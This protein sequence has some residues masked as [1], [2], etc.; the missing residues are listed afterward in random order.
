MTKKVTDLLDQNGIAYELYSDIKPNPTIENVQHGVDAYVAGT[1]KPYDKNAV[2]AAGNQSDGGIGLRFIG[3]LAG[4]VFDFIVFTHGSR[5]AR[6]QQT[7]Q[8]D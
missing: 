3:S 4:I 2:I 5:Q 7:D 6:Q 8:D 1:G